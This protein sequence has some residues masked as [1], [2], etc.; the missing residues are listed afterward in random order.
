MKYDEFAFFNR[1]LAGMLQS[2]IPLEGALRQL[3]RD[4]REGRLREELAAL[5]AD[6]A[7]GVP[8]SDAL[9]KRGLPEIYKQT[10]LAGVQA[11]NLPGILTLLADYYEKRHAVWARLQGL[12]VYPVLV[13]AASLGLSCVFVWFYRTVIGAFASEMTWGGSLPADIP[14]FVWVPMAWIGVLALAFVLAFAVPA[15]RNWLRWH[16]PGF[17]ESNLAEFAATL[18][19]LLSSGAQ[20]GQA[21][22]LVQQVEP[23][24]A[25]ALEL[26]RWQQRLAAGHG[27]FTDLAAGGNV[28]PRLF[29]WLVGEG[30]ED[31]A[32]GFARAAEVYAERARYRVELLLYAALPVAVLVLGAMILLQVFFMVRVITYPL[33][34]LGD[35]LG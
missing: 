4:M 32:A 33:S 10:V 17:R 23:S 35:A 7:K 2:G 5:E 15:W 14:V 27:K 28:F 3:C 21:L 20:L 12:M 34:C 9:S 26:G 6:L 22:K 1:Q 24:G 16:L 29:L 18:R 11:N 13:L 19:L 8:L 31:L 30:G 25:V